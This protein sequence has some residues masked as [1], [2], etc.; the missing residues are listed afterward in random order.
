[1]DLFPSFVYMYCIFDN[2]QCSSLLLFKLL[3][4]GKQFLGVFLGEELDKNLFGKKLMFKWGK[5]VITGK[6]KGRNLEL[7]WI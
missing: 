2:F 4:L 3:L 5:L 1:M 6:G 7:N